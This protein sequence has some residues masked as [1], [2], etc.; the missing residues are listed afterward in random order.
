M[1]R[2][3][4]SQPGYRQPY[5]TGPSSYGTLSH[6]DAII[7]QPAFPVED[8]ATAAQTLYERGEQTRY[9]Y[10]QLALATELEMQKVDPMDKPI[11]EDVMSRVVK[12]IEEYSE[13]G[14]FHNLEAGHLLLKLY[15]DIQSDPLRQHAIERREKQIQYKATLEELNIPSRYKARA[16]QI[17]SDRNTPFEIDE[18]GNITGGFNPYIP[19]EEVKGEDI[20]KE[21]MEGWKA[22]EFKSERWITDTEGQDPWIRGIVEEFSGVTSEE[23]INGITNL[24]MN[25]TRFMDWVDA[26]YF[27]DNYDPDTGDIAAP[28][29][30]QL[31]L[32]M[33]IDPKSLGE[34]PS[35]SDKLNMGLAVLDGRVK[36]LQDETRE[37][38]GETISE[39]EALKRIAR[40][41]YINNEI[42]GVISGMGNKYVSYGETVRHKVAK[43]DFYYHLA[44]Q[45]DNESGGNI[46]L[47]RLG[48]TPVPQ[49]FDSIIQ[50][51]AQKGGELNQAELILENFIKNN[52]IDD[53]DNIQDPNIKAEYDEL[54]Y[55]TDVLQSD[56]NR[57]V[58]AKQSI[59]D[60]ISDEDFNRVFNSYF[61][62]FR[63][64]INELDID[65]SRLE[66]LLKN[67]NYEEL[68]EILDTQI[69]PR[70]SLTMAARSKSGL[71]SSQY[72]ESKGLSTYEN[73]V[74]FIDRFYKQIDNE[75]V[76]AD[77]SESHLVMVPSEDTRS[78]EIREAQREALDNGTFSAST[79]D[80][81]RSTTDEDFRKEIYGADH[82]TL[83]ILSNI[84]NGNFTYLLTLRNGND[85]TQYQLLGSDIEGTTAQ[86]LY[87]DLIRAAESNNRLT[88]TER[89]HRLNFAKA[90]FAASLNVLHTV[91]DESRVDYSTTLH[92]R[93]SQYHLDASKTSTTTKDKDIDILLPREDGNR[94]MRLRVIKTATGYRVQYDRGGG[95][96][97]SIS[98]EIRN[99]G[100]IYNNI[101]DSYADIYTLYN[102]LL[103]E[104]E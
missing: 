25:D 48:E 102:K 49:S 84:Q 92:D 70:H 54:V 47:H 101:A 55:H 46:E 75:G 37:V 82:R 52:N 27:M 53:V 104:R 57:L 26:K 61:R 60:N 10:E 15:R 86:V 100:A 103:H 73:L 90:G 87:E 11:I 17:S 31:A 72:R 80:G 98:E 45:R 62:Q 9:G 39:E 14:N 83:D 99:R 64:T 13:G 33:P 79:V 38:T 18:N 43:N 23:V 89:H 19:P 91:G 40:Q 4:Y 97:R 69:L 66:T 63:D 20:V 34:N 12:P 6:S 88:N 28:N 35:F 71:T 22:G 95:N 81:N 7:E 24:L 41:E 32:S 16:E 51:L 3:R 74:H 29:P 85:I 50:S 1:Y 8:F 65:P 30:K 42:F 56:Y 21:Y 58:F 76:V 96:Y 5:N 93:L 2:Q 78:Y 68:I 44:K 36:R 67:Q 94:I 59:I 77:L